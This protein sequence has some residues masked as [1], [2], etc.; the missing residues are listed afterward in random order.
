MPL[1]PSSIADPFSWFG[2]LV[3]EG[4]EQ[5][6]EEYK[7]NAI[8]MKGYFLPAHPYTGRNDESIYFIDVEENSEMNSIGYSFES[9]CGERYVEEYGNAVINVN[10][11]HREIHNPD[12]VRQYIDRNILTLQSLK[13]VVSIKK[14]ANATELNN[15]LQQLIQYLEKKVTGNT[16]LSSNEE[17]LSNNYF[18]FTGTITNV[19]FLFHSLADIGLF[20]DD[21]ESQKELFKEVITGP[22]KDPNDKLKIMCNNGKAAFIFQHL[23]SLF[24]DL[25]FSRIEASQLFINRNGKPITANDLSKALNLFSNKDP[26]PEKDQI[27]IHLQ[28]VTKKIG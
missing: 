23:K 18:G 26:N 7:S 6:H 12:S 11:R 15:V 5:L 17:R 24:R 3:K 22:L 2:S 27:E 1:I 8:K 13:D 9:Y 14:L 4:D 21:N 25:S 19:E 10:E 20:D 16:V 28:K